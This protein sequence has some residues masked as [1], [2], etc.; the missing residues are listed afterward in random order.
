M[1]P[2]E[3]LAM[4]LV[5]MHMLLQQVFMVVVVGVGI[6]KLPFLVRDRSKH[7][8]GAIRAPTAATAAAAAGE[9]EGQDI[10]D[11]LRQGNFADDGNDNGGIEVG[12]RKMNPFADE[13]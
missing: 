1:F 7:G 5:C 4:M 10:S 11:Y 9:S 13:M 8:G 6:T 12:N 3:P 2:R